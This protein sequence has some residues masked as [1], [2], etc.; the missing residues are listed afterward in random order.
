[1]LSRERD[2]PNVEA[3]VTAAI[4]RFARY[5]STLDVRRDAVRDLAG[6]LEFLRPKVQ[7]VPTKKDEA[8]LFSIANGFGIRHHREDQ[9]TDYDRDIWH[10]FMFYYYLAMIH[11]VLRLIKKRDGEGF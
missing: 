9:K 1:M 5:K 8:D 2:W 11:A 7:A 4:S 10:T 3:R 6:V